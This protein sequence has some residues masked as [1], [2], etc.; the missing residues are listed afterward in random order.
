MS[1]VPEGMLDRWAERDPIDRYARRLVSEHGFTENDVEL[2]QAE[3]REYVEQCAAKALDSPMPEP[4]AATAGVFADSWEPLGDG[5]APWSAH[6]A[7]P[8]GA[9]NGSGAHGN[10][11]AQNADGVRS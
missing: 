6:S 11:L 2:I 4:E 10:G 5:A 1:Y 3:V 7:A 8:T 9:G